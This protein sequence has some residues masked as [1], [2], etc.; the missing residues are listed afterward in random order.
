M[1]EKLTG[2]AHPDS[3]VAFRCDASTIIG[4]G[5]VSR[6]LTLADELTQDGGK[7]HFICRPYSSDMMDL[8]QQRGH[9]VHIMSPATR[10]VDKTDHTTWLGTTLHED[11]AETR[12]ILN[13]IEPSRVVVDHYS[14]DS[15]WEAEAISARTPLLVIDD[16][17]NRPHVCDILL[18]QNLGRAAHDYLPLTPAGTTLLAGPEYALLRPEFSIFRNES[19]ARR[20]N[21]ELK[22]IVVSLGGA[23]PNGVTQDVVS[24][25]SNLSSRY[26]LRLTVI[27]GVSAPGYDAVLHAAQ[28]AHIPVNVIKGCDNMAQRLVAAD[29]VIGAAGGSAWERACLGAPALHLILAENQASAARTMQEMGVSKLVGDVRENRWSERLVE[30]IQEISSHDLARLS[31]TSS[32]ICDGLGAKRVAELI[33]NSR[34]HTHKATLEDAEMIYRWRNDAGATR[35]YRNPE[36]PIYRSHLAWMQGALRDASKTL[37]MVTLDGVPVGHVRFDV[38]RQNSEC[39]TIGICIDPD[40]RGLG[41]GPRVLS[42]GLKAAAPSFREIVAEV[43]LE[44]AASIHLF[45]RAGFLSEREDSHFLQMRRHLPPCSENLVAEDT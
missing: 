7:C 6:C 41:L 5:H 45:S 16:L 23:N 44:N 38:C 30:E 37:L 2:T 24:A 12:S 11:A 25:L 26:A 34:W 18:D 21:P 36:T 42:E 13:D 35:F 39:A 31:A 40:R 4:T 10:P 29:L 22:H 8:I 19:L 20:R 33:S 9:T 15:N 17:A 14:I 43:H 27:M 1:I 32:K 3:V 28:S